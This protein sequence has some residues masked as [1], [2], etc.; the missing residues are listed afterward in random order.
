[1]IVGGDVVKDAGIH[2]RVRPTCTIFVW[3]LRSWREF[4]SMYWYNQLSLYRKLPC[5]STLLIGMQKLL[6][7]DQVDFGARF[8]GYSGYWPR[9]KFTVS[10]L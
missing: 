9:D 1:M 2:L 6:F 7:F 8:L 10:I 5:P 4:V 3:R